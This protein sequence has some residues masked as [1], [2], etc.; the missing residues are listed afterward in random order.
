MLSSESKRH[1]SPT[2]SGL[3]CPQ[4][5]IIACL[6]AMGTAPESRDS[7]PKTEKLLRALC[8]PSFKAQEI[9]ASRQPS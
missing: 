5:D 3:V 8:M 4:L 7:I 1:G 2:W 9:S 6:T